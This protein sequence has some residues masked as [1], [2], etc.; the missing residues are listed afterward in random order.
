MILKHKYEA[1]YL[2]CDEWATGIYCRC[3][4]V[5][6]LALVLGVNLAVELCKPMG[7]GL[8]SSES[9]CMSAINKH[10]LRVW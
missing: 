10:T 4:E 7:V 8:Q 9:L 5:H 6:E 2:C 1:R 3:D